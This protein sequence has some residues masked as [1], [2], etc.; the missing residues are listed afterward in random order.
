MIE[1][2]QTLN[3][4]EKKVDVEELRSAGAD[5]GLTPHEEKTGARYREITDPA[6]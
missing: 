6:S 5:H 1:H 4:L 2:L 3:G